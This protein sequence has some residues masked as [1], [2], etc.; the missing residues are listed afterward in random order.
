[1]KTDNQDEELYPYLT[2]GRKLSSGIHRVKTDTAEL[3]EGYAALQES[4]LL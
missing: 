2:T 3:L 4:L 1:M